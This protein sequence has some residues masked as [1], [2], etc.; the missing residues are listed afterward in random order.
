LLPDKLNLTG[1]GKLRNPVIATV[2]AL[3]CAAAPVS[4]A[5]FTGLGDLPGG[6]FDSYPNAVSDDGLVVVGSGRS[7]AGY[8]GFVW[9]PAAGMRSVGDLPGGEHYSGAANV[10]P[11]GSV[12]VG[13]S[14]G[15]LA[16]QDWYRDYSAYR[17]TA[18]TGMTKLLPDAANPAHRF[19]RPGAASTA[20][21]TIVGSGIAPANPNGYFVSP[22]VWTADAGST[23]VLPTFGPSLPGDKQAFFNDV[24]PDGGRAVGYAAFHHDHTTQPFEWTPGGGFSPLAVPAANQNPHVFG[25]SPNSNYINGF[26]APTGGGTARGIVWDAARTP[27]LLDALSPDGESYAQ[28]V[29]NSGL[30][31][32]SAEDAPNDFHATIWRNS[33]QPQKLRDYLAQ[34][35]GLAQQLQ[36]WTLYEATAVSADGLTI[37]GYGQAPDGTYQGW[38]AR[39]DPGSDFP[40]AALGNYR[41]GAT[42]SV[43]ALIQRGDNQTV[44][45]QLNGIPV[46]RDGITWSEASQ[47]VSETPPFGTEQTAST[48]A[49][50]TNSIGTNRAEVRTATT[51]PGLFQVAAEVR[52]GWWDY[53]MIGGG[54]G[55]G[56][57]TLYFRVHGIL[58]ADPFATADFDVNLVHLS[59]PSAGAETNL[60]AFSRS[61]ATPG[62]FTQI[63]PVELHF[64]YNQPF[65]LES[66]LLLLASLNGSADLG[67]TVTLDRFE[68]PLG[69]TV[70]SSGIHHGDAT[71]AAYSFTAVPEPTTLTLLPLATAAL[72]LRRRHRARHSVP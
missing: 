29:S 35:H 65:K 15:T 26:T 66:E 33:T 71:P 19:A 38:V 23:P 69:A 18:P 41:A 46:V 32:G 40:L 48:Y 63:L 57:A 49:A 8:E 44:R 62:E 37:A 45:Q 6:D 59:G 9:T 28:S 5:L 52:T 64:T 39:L 36:G 2:L 20:G 31:V 51:D 13:M 25:I 24:T 43:K 3:A 54:T 14:S 4:A 12:V 53:F 56:T 16:N 67:G 10:S 11:D 27:T 50:F 58:G 47:S 30:V 7:A 61:H 17:W 72:S 68:I 22:Y 60:V 34:E 21:Q 1:V 55:Q 42:N 70:N